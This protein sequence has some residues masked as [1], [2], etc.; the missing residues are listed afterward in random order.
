VTATTRGGAALPLDRLIAWLAEHG[1]VLA[2]PVTAELTPYGRSNLTYI[3]SDAVGRKVVVRRPPLG[4]VLATA[5]DMS[6][7][8]RFISGLHDS[9]ATPRVPVPE[10]L[11]VCPGTD[12]IG[13]PFFV[14]SYVD[15]LVAETLAGLAPPGDASAAEAVRQLVSILATLHGVDFAAAGLQSFARPGSYLQR[16]L[17]R[18]KAAF[19][20][21]ACR[22]IAAVDEVYRRLLDAPPEQRRTTIVHGDYRIGNVICGPGGDI[23]AVL[24]WE[25]AT[26]G[27]PLADLAWLVLDCPDAG[28]AHTDPGALADAYA[29]ATGADVGELPYY[30][31]FAHWRG[32]CIL[33]G[34]TT[35][36]EAGVMA[37]DGFRPVR[38][39]EEIRAKADTAL[40]ILDGAASASAA[41]PAANITS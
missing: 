1:V 13:A 4:G 32:A 5:H 30:V 36:Y 17:H 41:T 3:L 22:E 29:R 27:D 7:E 11:A 40:A 16:Q 28:A 15:G 39:R 19:D 35:R 10:P 12:V 21:S 9:P 38:S 18:W 25:L 37:D 14:M 26:I 8:W 23:R 34:V 20:Q 33:A 24:D 6:R 2:V 31:A